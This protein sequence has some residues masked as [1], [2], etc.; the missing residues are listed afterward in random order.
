MKKYLFYILVTFSVVSCKKKDKEL[1]QNNNYALALPSGFPMPN[2]PE[3]NKLTLERIDLGK[4]LFFDKLLSKDQTISCGSCHAQEIAFSDRSAFSLG[5]NDSISSRNSMPLINLAWSKSF[6]WDGGV[7]TLE[8]QVIA[9][10]ENHKEMNLSLSE[11]IARLSSH[12][13]YPALFKKTYDRAPDVFSLVRAISCYERT[14]ISGNSKFDQYYYQGNTTALTTSELKGMNLFFSDSTHCAS[15]HN[16]INFTNGTFQN[17]GIYESYQDPGRYKI[18]YDNADFGKF[19]VPT[20]R[21]IALTG[22][23]MHDGSKSTLEEVLEHYLSGGKNNTNKSAHVHQLHLSNEEKA[24]LLNFL[25]A[26]TDESFIANPNFK[27]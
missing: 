5:V 18:T 10:I 15:C 1:P 20:L 23:Y 17:N 26:L 21:N 25:K 7:P 2:I 4:K 9:P 27:P 14:L 19:K 12:P 13:E 11:A 6:F 8:L 22:P 24:D 3:D 16:G